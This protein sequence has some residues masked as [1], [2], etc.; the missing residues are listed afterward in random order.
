MPLTIVPLDR[1][2]RPGTS[3]VYPPF[4]HGRYLEEYVYSYLLERQDEI[5]SDWAYLPVFWTHLQNHPAFRDRRGSYQV[6]L[7]RA[8]KAMPAGT[9][10]FT[11]VQHDDGVP[12]ELPVGTVVFGAC[13]GDRP[14]PL[15]Y[16]DTRHTLASSPR[17]PLGERDILLSFVGTTSTHPVRQES[18]RW[19][20]GKDGVRWV[21]RD[22]W[23]ATVA[24]ADA[25]QF[26]SVTSR[27]RFCFAPRGYGRSSFRFVEAMLLDT[28][29]VYVWDDVEWLPYLS[30]VDY[31]A[32]SISIHRSELPQLYDRLRAITD[33][34]YRAMQVELRRVRELWFSLEG[35]CAWLVG[36]ITLTGSASEVCPVGRSLKDS[37]RLESQP[38]VSYNGVPRV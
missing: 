4:K 10:Y 30:A 29:P 34:Q 2:F 21:S 16:E 9:R 25:D 3:H 7:N 14:L 5:S 15:I 19:L 24:E 22:T 23:S 11:V 17:I 36:E 35:M 20:E 31:S 13:T 1:L 32:F 8:L 27:S 12:L 26:I 18:R 6:L 38:V 28:V 37:A 33:E